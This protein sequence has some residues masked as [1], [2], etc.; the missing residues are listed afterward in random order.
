[1]PGE[2]KLAGSARNLVPSVPAFAVP[3]DYISVQFADVHP[4]KDVHGTGSCTLADAPGGGIALYDA[5]GVFLAS[6]A[7]STICSLSAMLNT[8]LCQF[9]NAFATAVRSPM[10]EPSKSIH[11]CCHALQVILLAA[12][13]AHELLV[14]RF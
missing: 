13:W 9:N 10:Y 14:L 1:M 2:G 5:Q 11:V 8:L 12:G 4:N 6:M 7:P 3:G